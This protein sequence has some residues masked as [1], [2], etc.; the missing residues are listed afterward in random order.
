MGRLFFLLCKG[1]RLL[2]SLEADANLL[3]LEDLALVSIV[4]HSRQT[5]TTE[6]KWGP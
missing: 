6:W 1:V 5:A 2:Q 4:F 3:G